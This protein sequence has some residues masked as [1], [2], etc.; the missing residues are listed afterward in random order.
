MKTGL[1]LRGR[2]KTCQ[3]YEEARRDRDSGLHGSFLGDGGSP[4]HRTE[5]I[6]MT[7]CACVSFFPR[8]VTTPGHSVYDR[9]RRHSIY[10]SFLHLHDRPPWHITLPALGAPP[11]SPS[12]TIQPICK[13]NHGQARPGIS[14]PV[15]SRQYA[16]GLTNSAQPSV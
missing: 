3:R 14:S 12:P 16:Q 2:S 4:K 9:S 5:K 13:A 11:S 6:W 7:G 10:F 15:W 1:G 8:C